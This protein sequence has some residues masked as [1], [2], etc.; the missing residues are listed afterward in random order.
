ME[1][2]SVL[3]EIGLTDKEAAVY[4]ATLELGQSS[5]LWI[6]KK[7]AVKR[8]TAY[9]TLDALQERGLVLSIPKGTTTLYQAI[10]PEEVVRRFDERVGALKAVLPELK[11]LFN[12]VPGKPKVRFYEGKKNI[13]A[14]YED[15]IF[16][17]GEVLSAFS[18]KD[19][20]GVYSTDEMRG[21][22]HLMKANNVTIRDLLQ[23]APEAHEYAKEKD[24][25]ELGQSKFLPNNFS[26]G[27]D[28]L[29]YGNAVVMVSFRNLMAVAIEDPTIANAQRQFLEFLW[30]S[31]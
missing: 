27:V 8:P 16:Q 18:P 2:K 5:V 26:I 28:V 31:I 23:D 6:A 11:S 13:L 25:L 20:V 21:L 17:G 14:L 12:V 7:A 15:E 19:W 22:L 24:R 30:K 1:I 29:I 3:K 9:V 10:D 4:L